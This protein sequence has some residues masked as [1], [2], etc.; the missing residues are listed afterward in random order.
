ME[1]TIQLFAQLIE[2]FPPLLSDDLAYRF[3]KELKNIQSEPINLEQLEQKMV[4]VGYEIWPWN[5]AFREFLR[6]TEQKMGEEF[7]LAYLSDDLKKKY[8]RY[9]QLGMSW[10]DI[11]TGRAASYFEEEERIIIAEALVSAHQSIRDF[12]VREVVGIKKEKYLN[13]VEEFKGILTK[14]KDGLGKLRDLATSEGDHPMLSNEI[15]ERVKS[16][17]HGLCLLAPE[18]DHEEVGQAHEF[19]K[20]RRQELNRL[21]GIHETIEIDFYEEN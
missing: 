11:H 16:F 8:F 13:K 1:S 5:Q 3:R 14:I 20:G 6:L 10:Q 18:F 9:S 17:E 4:Q 19:F 7:L 12:T 2:N 15:T 21:R